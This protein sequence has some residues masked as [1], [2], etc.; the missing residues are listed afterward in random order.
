M[1]NHPRD[2]PQ[3]YLTSPAPCPYLPNRQERK[4]FTHLVGEDAQQLNE[5]LSHGG[6]R[7]SQTIAYRP[8]CE[9]CSACVSTRVLAQEFKFSASHRRIFRHNEDLIGAIKPNK[10]TSEQYA[11]FRHYVEGRHSD[12]GMVD[13]SMLDYTMMV[14]SSHIDTILIEYRWR[15]ID[16]WITK[17]G[18]G[19][20]IAVSLVDRFCDGFSMVYS[21]YRTIE[22]DDMGAAQGVLNTPTSPLLA[23]RS[24]GTWMILDQIRRAQNASLPHVY[25]GYWV[26]DSPKMGYKARFLPQE[27]L[28][29]SGWARQ[30]F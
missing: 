30:D 26:Q 15:G 18:M 29:K 4:V 25:L 11:L 22:D 17:E 8:M 3:F 27:H 10:A 28:S 5:L 13:M 6:F 16:S 14:E 1:S 21:F 20:L 19:A 2:T 7:R 24:L 12:G 23:Q 9:G